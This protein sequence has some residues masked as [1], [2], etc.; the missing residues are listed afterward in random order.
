MLKR[1][2]LVLA[3]LRTVPL[4]R[5]P[6]TVATHEPRLDQ[7]RKPERASRERAVD[8]VTAEDD[9]VDS[10]GCHVAKRG[11]E[12]PRHAVHVVERGNPHGA[13]KA[14]ASSREGTASTFSSAKP[15][16]G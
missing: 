9:Q 5:R 14:F 12:R 10:L 15:S 4:R 3:E 2:Q 6:L 8:Q 11:F 13:K 1:A 16:T 7:A